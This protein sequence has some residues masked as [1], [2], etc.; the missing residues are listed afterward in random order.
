MALRRYV[1]AEIRAYLSACAAGNT[2]ERQRKLHQ[3]GWGL[4]YIL[5]R[6][7][8]KNSEWGTD[9]WLDY[10]IPDLV[11]IHNQQVLTVRGFAIWGLVSS[12]WCEWAEPVEITLKLSSTLRRIP[13]FEAKLGDAELGL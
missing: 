12:S 11:T 2:L 3:L 6:F 5:A 1:A 8:R 13:H 9:R 4:G 10:I 7:L